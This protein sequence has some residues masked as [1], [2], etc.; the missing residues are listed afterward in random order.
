MTSQ[1]SVP[2]TLLATPPVAAGGLL[3]AGIQLSDWVMI[4]T[5]IYT[6]FLIIDKIPN[7]T[8]RLREFIHWIKGPSNE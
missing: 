7:V 4:G 1:S 5:A 3:L 8:Q 6:L 2:D